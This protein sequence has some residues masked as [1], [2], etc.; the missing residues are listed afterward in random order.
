VKR[1]MDLV[2]A[3]VLFLITLPLQILIWAMVKFDSPGPALHRQRRFSLGG[4][5]FTFF[6]FR[7]MFVDARQR[8][9]ELYD[10][11]A[12]VQRNGNV[13]LKQEGDPRI[14]RVGRWLRRSS[15][16]ELPNLWNVVRGDMSLVGPR[17]E[18]PELLDC[19]SPVERG[20]FQVKPG[21]TGL[22]QIS[23]R[24]RLT[25]AE[26]IALD[27]EYARRWSLAL[28]FRILLRTLQQIARGRDAY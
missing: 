2:G 28:D 17:P 3:T 20:V 1:E 13:P 10:Y 27:L 22:P 5:T 4:G 14:T 7:T 16:D 11:A 18:I 6:K 24:N 15:L 12:I 19:Y 21:I 23:G 25:V 26:T 8:F 9:P